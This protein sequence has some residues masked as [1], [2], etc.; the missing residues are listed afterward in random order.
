[1]VI[2]EIVPGFLR[3]V[4]AMGCVVFIDPFNPHNR[5]SFNITQRSKICASRCRFYYHILVHDKCETS[6]FILSKTLAF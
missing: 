5:L 4:D 1:M 6:C 2:R 3:G